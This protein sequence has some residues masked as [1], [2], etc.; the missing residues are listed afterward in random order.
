MS[1]IWSM[2]TF[3]SAATATPSALATADPRPIGLSAAWRQKYKY[4]DLRRAI[5]SHSYACIRKTLQQ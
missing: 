3:H 5:I 4:A 2:G 1:P